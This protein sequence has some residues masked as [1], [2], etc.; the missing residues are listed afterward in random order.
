MLKGLLFDKDGT[1]FDFGGTWNAWGKGVL[2]GLAQGDAGLLQ[3]LA[4][5]LRFD[6][7][8][9]SFRADSPVI[10]ETNRE[11]AELLLT[12]LP[13]RSLEAL[14][15]YLTEEA[16]K[17]PLEPVT[18]LPGLMAAL[19]GQGYVLGVM[20]NDA[21]VSARHQVG[22]AGIAPYLSFVAGF[23]SGH[24]AKPD[25]DPLLAFARASGLDPSRVAMV[26]DSTHDLMAGRAAGMICI[27]V[28]TGMAPAAELAPHAH[29]ILPDIS[30][31][32]EWLAGQA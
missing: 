23:D 8:A 2:E 4:R 22:A 30:H 29:V 21:E 32:P 5:A 1:L 26:G 14:E 11:V 19:Q 24:G 3:A 18:D 27:G 20:T 17:A 10:A 6:L 25:P 15:H 9:G 16:A 28:L 13:G 12:H 31:L 7:D